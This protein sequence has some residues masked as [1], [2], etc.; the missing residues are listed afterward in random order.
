MEYEESR[1]I[2]VNMRQRFE[3]QWTQNEKKAFDN[4]MVLLDCKIREI[5]Q[6]IA[7]MKKKE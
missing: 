6:R 3:K 4:V 7:E 2:L 1:T 5:N